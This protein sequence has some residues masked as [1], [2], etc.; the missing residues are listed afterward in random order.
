[1]SIKIIKGEGRSWRPYRFPPRVRPAAQG[2]EVLAGDPAALQRA[3]AEGFQEGIDKGYEQG[4]EQGREAGHREG[5][6]RGIEDG[7]AIGREEGRI[8][9]LKAFEQA[10][11]PLDQ[12][13]ERFERFR[14]DFEQARREQLL[15]LVQ[16]VSK[17]VIRCELTLHPTQL[18]T[19]AEEALAAM[20]DDQEDVRILLNP[21]ECARIRE[22]APER[23]AAWRLVPDEKLALGECRVV[24]AQAEADIGCQQRLDSCMDTLA[25]H[26]K[27]EA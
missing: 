9:G 6:E 7:K 22:L 21:E 11:Q 1:M 16:K 19:L 13:V 23:A 26:I 27:A 17:Q 10:A 14:Q 25:E 18:L 15:E 8:Q 2:D 20:P 4:L 5:F 12:L 24:T 3:V